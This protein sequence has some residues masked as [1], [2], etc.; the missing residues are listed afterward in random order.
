M[1]R[2]RNPSFGYRR[3]RNPTSSWGQ[4]FLAWAMG[5]GSGVVGYGINWGVEFIPLATI[6]RSVIF[7][8][9]GAAGS[10]AL[11]KWADPRLGSGLAG[12]T[13][14]LLTGRIVTQIRLAQVSPTSGSTASTP[15]GGALYRRNP[16]AQLDAGRV[17]RDG[18]AV[19]SRREAGAPVRSMK[20]PAFGAS[21]RDAG[22]SRYVQGPIRYF[23]P[24]SWV[25]GPDGGAVR[26]VSAHNRRGG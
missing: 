16:R 7:G 26:R 14:A 18:G 8:G 10:L 17:F 15:E 13:G 21:F 20:S 2:R 23:G 6:W 4:A 25:Y 24:R 22:A 19:F 5:M 1:R 11:A 9:V 3:R 12:A